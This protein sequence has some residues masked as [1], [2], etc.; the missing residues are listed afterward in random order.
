MINSV[1][2]EQAVAA[3]LQA[4]LGDDLTVRAAV[5]AEEIEALE[6]AIEEARERGA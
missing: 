1:G 6:R 2:L 3:H 5:S 4:I